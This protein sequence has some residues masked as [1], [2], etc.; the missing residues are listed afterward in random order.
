[1]FVVCC[2]LFVLSFNLFLFC[3]FPPFVCTPHPRTPFPLFPFVPSRPFFP[4]L[5]FRLALFILPRYFHFASLLSFR[6]ASFISPRFFH[7]A[8]L[9]SFRLVSFISPCFCH[10]ASLLSRPLT[11]APLV[12]HTFSNANVRRYLTF[13]DVTRYC[14]STL[15]ATLPKA[16][17]TMNVDA[18]ENSVNDSYRFNPWRA[19]LTIT[20]SLIVQV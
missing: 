13:G 1:L 10:F 9:L 14:N 11:T 17:W 12:Q 3:F 16:A 8:S 15:Q 6:L 4:L 2:L 19:S 5:P 7:F 20:L 18:V